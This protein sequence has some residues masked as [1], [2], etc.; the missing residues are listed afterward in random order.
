MQ[1]RWN[2]GQFT[3]NLNGMV[4]TA[5]ATV[6]RYLHTLVSGSPECDW[7][8][9]VRANH[10]PP[11]VDRLLV[12]GAGSG[13]LERAL[14]IKDGIGS[15]TAC[16]FAPE[17]VAAAEKTAR[18]EGLDIRY[19]VRNLEAEPL[20]EGPFDAV[21]ANDVL[22][23]I[24]DLEGLYAR[25]HESLVPGGKLLFNEYV[26]P[27][28]FQY[29]DARMDVINRYF[30]LIPDHLRFNPYW[31]GLFWSR[32]RVDPAKLAADD[33]TEAVRSEDVLPLARRY[34]D[35]EKE[36]S[37]GGGLLNPLLYEII[38][39]FDETNP[40]DLGLLELFCAAEDRLTRAGVIE[41]D[42]SV[43]VG[44]RRDALATGP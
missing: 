14:A 19:F 8:T 42:F 16:D 35:V 41:P 17:T 36:Y 22:H 20:P 6:R 39:S 38:A 9:W 25:I 5:S 10:L 12:L 31:S 11:R 2:D 4:W 15:I 28:R 32:F 34:F 33:P 13:W 37:Y 24:T 30:R 27:N 44:R 43:F 18:Q 23:H 26:G 21:V 40:R 7:P 29:S 3:G 1:T